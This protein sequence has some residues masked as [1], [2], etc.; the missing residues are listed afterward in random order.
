M[1]RH[2]IGSVRDAVLAF[3]EHS[4]LVDHDGGDVVREWAIRQ[5]CGV[6]CWEDFCW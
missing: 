2:G 1:A 4:R 3:A 5:R 6:G